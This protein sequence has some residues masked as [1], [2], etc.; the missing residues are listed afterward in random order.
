M[1]RTIDDIKYNKE[2]YMNDWDYV[3]LMNLCKELFEK[4]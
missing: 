2:G 3:Q 1:C 4:I